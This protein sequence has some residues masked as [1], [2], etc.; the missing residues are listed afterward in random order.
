MAKPSNPSLVAITVDVDHLIGENTEAY[1]ITTKYV[2]KKGTDMEQ[3]IA[4]TAQGK[5]RFEPD[6]QTVG[7]QIIDITKIG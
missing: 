3:L 5:Y 7:V 2:V 4:E 6:T 1:N